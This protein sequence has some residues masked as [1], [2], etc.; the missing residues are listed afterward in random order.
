MLSNVSGAEKR[1][2]EIGDGLLNCVRAR[3]QS[4]N[5]WIKFERLPF[6]E[7]Y[8]VGGLEIGFLFMIETETEGVKGPVIATAPRKQNIFLCLRVK[9]AHDLTGFE[10]WSLGGSSEQLIQHVFG[11][12]YCL[13][14]KN[15]KAVFIAGIEAVKPAEDI[16]PARIRLQRAYQLNDICSG[17]I[18]LS[19]LNSA[20][21]AFRFSN[22]WEDELEWAGGLIVR[23]PI[24]CHIQGGTEIVNG[25]ADDKRHFVRDWFQPPTDDCVRP[26]IGLV[27][28]E[29]SKRSLR[30]KRVDGRLKLLDVIFG[31]LNLKFGCEGER[32]SGEWRHDKSRSDER[33]RVSKSRAGLPAHEPEAA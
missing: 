4:F 15:E 31:P 6:S 17:E 29:K 1:L 27:L 25:V 7:R 24:E 22:E 2:D 11:E 19:A 20:L 12:I 14:R 30:Q 13:A 5:D 32:L 3:Q 16:I 21:K 18:Y 33:A 28:D 8:A 26:S 10:G 9:K 23:H